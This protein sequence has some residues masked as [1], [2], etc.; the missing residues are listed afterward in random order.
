M[1]I[2]EII[3]Y[4]NRER[5]LNMPVAQS[6]LATQSIT[7][8]ILKASQTV[9]EQGNGYTL[10]GTTLSV[11]TESANEKAG[12]ETHY[13]LY[14]GTNAPISSGSYTVDSNKSYYVRWG[15][16]SNYKPSPF[17]DVALEVSVTVVAYPAAM[18]SVSVAGV[19]S[20]GK[21]GLGDVVTVT[22]LPGRGCEFVNWQYSDGTEASES[23]GYSFTATR[24]VILTAVF[25]PIGKQ[26]ASVPTAIDGLVYT[27]STQTGIMEPAQTHYTWTADSVRQAVNAGIYTATAV[28]EYGYVW[29]DGT[30]GVKVLTW[31]L[32]KAPQDAPDG[33]TA[34]DDSIIGT[35]ADME[36]RAA[37][38][39]SY[40]NA[41]DGSVTG[42]A[43]GTYYVRYREDA[44][45]Y[46]G[47]IAVLTVSRPTI[48]AVTL[49]PSRLDRTS[50]ALNGCID[51]RNAITEGYVS[52]VGFEYRKSG[53]AAWTSAD[54]AMG[55]TFNCTVSGL[56]ANAEY[57]CRSVVTL[58]D[59]GTVRGGEVTFHTPAVTSTA[60]G[61][62]EVSIVAENPEDH[63]EI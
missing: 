30:E 27:G 16:S 3:C 61:R 58:T 22:A 8:T 25:K 47:D 41:A 18:G 26:L 5:T 1:R 35:T 13:E 23:T 6:R 54:A 36:Y 43:P 63:R 60:T 15:G 52:G 57:V 24:S 49:P 38:A 29:S 44:N 45:H 14:D 42:L 50:A 10:N 4:S 31:R 39:E 32:G 7:S 2:Y 20:S 11:D 9:P 12:Y 33:L 34:T 55:D 48:R 51:P 28:L 56:T 62:I 46:P 19:D 40:K 37:D 59:G 53:D 17:T 21:C